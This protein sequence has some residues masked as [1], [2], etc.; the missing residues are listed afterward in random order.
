MRFLDCVNRGDVEVRL[1]RGAPEVSVA[2]LP[3]GPRMA[4]WSRP[5]L[6]WPTPARAGVEPVPLARRDE[7]GMERGMKE[8]YIEGVATHCRPEPAPA[9]VRPT[10]KRW[11]GVRAGRA[12]EP[13]N[14]RSGDLS[15]EVFGWHQYSRRTAAG[16]SGGPAPLL[17]G[18]TLCDVVILV[19]QAALIVIF[20]L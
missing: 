15:L 8:P 6:R 3:L 17:L 2:E 18:P 9:S 11:T 5:R 1:R 10:A 7:T 16:D 19:L 20:A 12:I 4:A 13:R 14:Q